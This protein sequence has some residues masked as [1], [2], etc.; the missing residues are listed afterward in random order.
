MVSL[1]TK[2][3]TAAVVVVVGG[4]DAEAVALGRV[5]EAVRVGGLDER[6]VALV[7]EEEVGLSGQAHGADHGLGT[8][9]PGERALGLPTSSQLVAT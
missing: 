2:R 6:P 8:A 7:L 9:S 5:L 1:A 4:E 3:S